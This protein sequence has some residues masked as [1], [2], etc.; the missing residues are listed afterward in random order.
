MT[1]KGT[2]T[3]QPHILIVEDNPTNIELMKEQLHGEGYDVEAVL[4]GEEALSYVSKNK[5][6][7]ILLDI[8]I[9]KRSGF[10]VCKI[11]KSSA[12]TR[13]IPVIMVT[14]L[15]DMESRVKGIAV[16]A[17]DFLSRP[18]DRTELISRV[19]S[20]LRIK[21]LDDELSRESK[22]ARESNEKLELQQRV[23]KSMSTQLM[24]ASHLKYEFIVN[25]SHALRTP[26]N[27][28]IGF[29]EMLQDGLVG[30]LSDKQTK[31][32]TNILESGRELQ[33]LIANIVDVFKIDTG[34][35]QLETTEFSLKDAIQSSL[36]TFEAAAR[37]ENITI[38]VRIAEDISRISADPQKLGTIL[39]NLLSNA[40]KFT[41]RGGIVTV[42]A[43]QSED[44]VQVCVADAGPGLSAEDCEKVF[45]EFYK[46]SSPGSTTTSGSGLGLAI[47]KKLVMMHGG[48]IWAER[49][50]EGGARFCFTLPRDGRKRRGR[51]GPD[52]SSQRGE[53]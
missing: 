4:D 43:E 38:N 42:T 29:S 36:R 27:V 34:K 39:D 44:S 40:F 25:M 33:Q 41:R 46:V 35:V 11:I 45:S 21:Q 8:M 47:S 3:R 30:T 24:Q 20:M 28:I 31:Y 5:P 1:T 53:Q 16:G 18:V 13:S 17:D 52:P 23:L 48:E 2:A 15:K 51:P 26:L 19:K 6:D 37:R 49:R 10:E 14:A 7:I 22:T 9:P 32:V 50:K 12:E